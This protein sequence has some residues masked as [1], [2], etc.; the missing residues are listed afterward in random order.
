MPQ[1]L[2]FG[3]AVLCSFCGQRLLNGECLTCDLQRARHERIRPN[4]PN[5]NVLMDDMYRGSLTKADEEFWYCGRCKYERSKYSVP[6]A[7]ESKTA[8]LP[9]ASRQPEAPKEVPRSETKIFGKLQPWKRAQIIA[10]ETTKSRPKPR[11]AFCQTCNKE[12]TTLGS[13]CPVC[14]NE[15]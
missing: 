4:C 13:K 12:R 7:P 8:I 1:P 15:I 2:G 3:N 5:C 9:L 6:K 10:E 11:K 14:H